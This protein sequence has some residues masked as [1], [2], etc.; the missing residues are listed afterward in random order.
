[1]LLLRTKRP[2]KSNQPYRSWTSACNHFRLSFNSP[3]IDSE[4]DSHRSYC[5]KRMILLL[6]HLKVYNNCANVADFHIVMKITKAWYIFLISNI[7]GECNFHSKV[8]CSCGEC[9]KDDKGLYTELKCDGKPYSS[10][11]PPLKCPLHALLYEIEC[12][13]NWLKTKW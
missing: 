9:P 12:K 1:M 3:T 10:S 6:F 4:F 5:S 2:T 13:V 8:V 7:T 11:M